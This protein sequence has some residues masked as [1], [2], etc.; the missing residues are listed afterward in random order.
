MIREDL[1]D[2][3]G[4]MK[5]MRQKREKHPKC[6]PLYQ[7]RQIAPRTVDFPNPLQAF[8]IVHTPPAHDDVV[9]I[10]EELD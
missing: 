10:I 2:H 4:K 5:E 7:S 9:P 8:A 1:D 6:V 3:L